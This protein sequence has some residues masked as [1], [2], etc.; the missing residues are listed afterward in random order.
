MLR[1]F[2][3][4]YARVKYRQFE[5]DLAEE[6]ESHRAMAQESIEAGGLSRDDARRRAAHA[7]GNITLAREDGRAMWIPLGWQ[8]LVQDA[9][10]ALRGLRRSPGFSLAAIGMLT[11]GLGLVAGGYTVVNGLFVRG[12]AVPDNSRVFTATARRATL[13]ATGLVDDGPSF[14][15]FKH[16]RASART[17]DIV[18]MN[19]QYF[20]IHPDRGVRGVHMPGMFV[21]DNFIDTLRIPLQSGTGSLAAV[22]NEPRIVISDRVWRNVFNTDPQIVGRTVWLNAV[23]VTVAGVTAR[24][25]DGLGP[26]QLDVV[27]EMTLAVRLFSQ[28]SVTEQIKDETACCV[29]LA[30]RI[31]GDWTRAQVQEE[32]EVLTA[33]YRRSMGQPPLTVAL[34]GTAP[35]QGNIDP[36]GRGMETTFALIGAAF[37]LVLLLTCANVG[38]L[39]L[40]RSLRRQRE[41]AVR[42]SLGASRARVVRQLLTE[43]LVMA[44]IAGAGAFAATTAVPALLYLLEDNST[45]TMF[46]SDWRVAAFTAAGVVVTCLVVSLAPAL[47]TTR[48]AW[49]GATATMSA[50]SGGLRKAVLAIQIAIATVLVL[51]A[52]LMTRSIQHTLTAPA[53][54]ALHTT[55]AVTLHAPMDRGYD[56]RKAADIRTALAGALARAGWRAGLADSMP[57]RGWAGLETFVRRPASD[58]E[59]RAQLVPLSATAFEILEV[60]LASG[61]WAS[62]DAAAGEA[63][64]NERLA[65]QLWP[66][67]NPLGQSL[68]ISFNRRTY[69]IIG[70]T[71]D[72]HLTSL[73][74]I[75]PTVHVAPGFGMPSL[76]V[77]TAPG[78]EQKIKTLVAAVDPALAVTVTPLSASMAR[79]LEFRMVGAGIAGAIGIVALLLAIVG[80]FG[81]FSYLVEERRRE[82][83]IR[84]AL[85]ASRAWIGGALFNASRGA[86]ASGLIVGLSLSVI[87]GLA[88]RRFLFGLSPVDPVSYL[89]VAAVLIIAAL[90]ATAIPIRRA[91]RVDPATTLKAE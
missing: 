57:R 82:I 87:A 74:E 67:E 51:S 58:V 24:S 43:G 6:L 41:I 27:A 31:R 53:D 13:P 11:L 32:L 30:G 23:P 14:G 21:S 42:Q 81:V 17:A 83:G 59:H 19:V 44:S 50:P 1:F 88:L 70:V 75:Q 65:R 61:R 49:R 68:A 86:V 35:A 56:A 85:G 18:A 25:F 91:L 10:Y 79:T 60:R 76:L 4:L 69:S 7:L 39:F 48:I 5:K 45:A 64:V 71:R 62:D 63:V 77:R 15:A 2:R 38:N 37:L 40:A 78:L 89:A 20:R 12:W 16:L 26:S 34:G 3:R 90:L 73:Q 8:Q 54:F 22:G 80:V 28:G 29:R 55:S 36:H 46:A 47:Q 72:A 52:T 9:R 33:Q 66:D 84:L